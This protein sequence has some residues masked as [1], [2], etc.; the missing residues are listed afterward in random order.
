MCLVIQMLI[1]LPSSRSRV[2]L[3]RYASVCYNRDM[4]LTLNSN[5]MH[6]HVAIMLK[7]K[8]IKLA[9]ISEVW[10]CKGHLNKERKQ[11]SRVFNGTALMS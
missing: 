6:S 11:R 8:N 10:L 1:T 9:Y 4:F 2:V 5:F 3:G 7:I